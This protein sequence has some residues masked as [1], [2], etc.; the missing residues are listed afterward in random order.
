MIALVQ[1]A[2]SGGAKDFPLEFANPIVSFG[3][4][5]GAIA[6]SAREFEKDGKKAPMPAEVAKTVIDA[7][8]KQSSPGKLWLGR[9]SFLFHYI[10]P[11]L[12]VWVADKIFSDLMNV[13]LVRT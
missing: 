4:V 3:N 7:V 13:K 6:Q 10:I 9:N 11:I 5:S 8:E 12:P 1:T 2:M